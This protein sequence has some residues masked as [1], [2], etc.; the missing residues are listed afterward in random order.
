VARYAG[1]RQLV[2]PG[3]DHGFADFERYLDGVLAFAGVA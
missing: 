3:S 1:A 2:V